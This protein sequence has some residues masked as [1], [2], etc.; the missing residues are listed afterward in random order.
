MRVLQLY[1]EL[2]SGN[3]RDVFLLPLPAG[4]LP[5]SKE[6]LAHVQWCAVIMSVALAYQLRL[7]AQLREEWALRMD[8]MLQEHNCP[9]HLSQTTAVVHKCLDRFFAGTHVPPGIAPTSALKE[10]I[11]ATV[12]CLVA[13]I[14]L[15]ITGPPGCGKTLAVQTVVENMKGL[16]S[17]MPLYKLLP[18]L[19][20]SELC[21]TLHK[22]PDRCFK[23]IYKSFGFIY[24]HSRYIFHV[25]PYQCS[26]SST[27]SEVAAVFDNAVNRSRA[28]RQHGDVILV[29]LDEA[30][31][32]AERRHALKVIHGYLDHPEVR[33]TPH[34]LYFRCDIV[35]TSNHTF[36]LRSCIF[37]LI[38]LCRW[39]ASCWPIQ[40]WTL[41]S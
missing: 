33:A 12:I 9:R 27:A 22:K 16:S 13:R 4:V 3:R 2:L 1:R 38:R 19:Q 15:N 36:L 31:L 20:Q 5:G 29:F 35:S 40:T 28:M 30:G 26:E 24:T 10:N 6:G 14:P 7:P 21:T 25:V 39:P 18:N 23:K 34:L 41:R 37:V 32:P 11:Y 17:T 8:E